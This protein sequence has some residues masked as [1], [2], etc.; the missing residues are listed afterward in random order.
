[1]SALLQALRYWA[2]NVFTATSQWINAVGGGDPQES[3]SSRVGKGARDG[4]R[5]WIIL[6]SILHRLEKNHCELAIDD[7]NGRNSV[8][9]RM[10]RWRTK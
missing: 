3:L 5:F 6:C 4:R 8:P 2:D 7:R 9:Q 10:A 1:M